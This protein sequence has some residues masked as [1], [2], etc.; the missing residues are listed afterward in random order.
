MA[1]I[2]NADEIIM[3]DHGKVVERGSHEEL[4]E[5]KGAYRSLYHSQFE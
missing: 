1:T 5:K 4:M 2:R 3:I